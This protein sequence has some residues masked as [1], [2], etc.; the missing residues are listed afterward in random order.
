M[1]WAALSKKESKLKL[2]F[3]EMLKLVLKIRALFHEA[4]EKKNIY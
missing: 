2:E 4:K 1:Q 3:D